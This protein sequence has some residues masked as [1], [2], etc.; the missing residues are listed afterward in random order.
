MR[1]PYTQLFIHLVWATWDRLL[2]IRPDYEP[3]LYSA[4]VRKCE[5]LHCKVIAVNGVADHVHVLTY[6]PATITIADLVQHIKG[7]TSHLM[8]HEIAP[9]RRFKW[10]GAYGAFSVSK[11]MTDKVATY[12]RNQKQHH[13]DRQLVDELEQSDVAI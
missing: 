5:A 6:I 1:K 3:R 11:M 7:S 4:I 13:R 9:E 10:Q 2:L 12:V 8:N